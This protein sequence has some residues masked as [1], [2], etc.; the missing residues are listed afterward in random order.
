MWILPTLSYGRSVEHVGFVG[1]VTL[2]TDTLLN[3]CR[4]IGRSLAARGFAGS[5]LSTDMAETLRF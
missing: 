5:S 2:S 3:V 1:T 4:D